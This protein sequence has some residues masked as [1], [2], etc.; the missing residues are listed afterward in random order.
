MANPAQASAASAI[1]FSVGAAVPIIAAVISPNN[2][3]A[4]FITV[5]SLA[6]LAV[7]GGIGA[8]VGGGHRIRAAVRVLLGGGIA[9]AITALIGHLIGKAI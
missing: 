1:S 3:N 7:S 9:M 2:M 6:A 4:V 8:Y 5:L